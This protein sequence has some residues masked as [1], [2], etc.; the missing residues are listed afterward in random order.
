[1][2]KRREVTAVEGATPGAGLR[3]EAGAA[4]ARPRLADEVYDFLLSQLMTLRIEPDARVTIDALARELGVSQTPIRDALSRLEADGL[5]VRV[6]LAGYRVA[7][8]ITR[9]QFEDLVE[10]R[11]LLEPSVARHAAE[12]MTPAQT[13]QLRGLLEDMARP[14]AGDQHLA[15]G[16]FGRRDAAFHDLIAVGGGNRVVRETLA[17]LHTHVHL[18]RLLYDAKVTNEAM[19]EHAEILEAIAAR[20]ADGAAY[21]MRR[22]ILRSGERF[23]PIFERMAAPVKK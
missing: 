8:Q 19:D 9:Q 3:G 22:H 12:R 17:R 7:P 18:F 1:M 13:E 10:I 20:D 6:H 5:V 23:R 2:A 16:I 15:Y 11:L 21:A 14:Q 4:S